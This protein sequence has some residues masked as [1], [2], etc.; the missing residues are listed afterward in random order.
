MSTDVWTK[1]LVNQRMTR[2]LPPEGSSVEYTWRCRVTNAQGAELQWDPFSFVDNTTT[3]L[4]LP[5]PG[6]KVSD[7]FTSIGG[8]SDYFRFRTLQWSLVPESISTWEVTATATSKDAFC[9]EPNV[10]RTD[11]VTSREVDVYRAIEPADTDRA[12]GN[13]LA[14]SFYADRAGKPIKLNLGQIQISISFIWNTGDDRQDGNGNPIGGYPN[15]A[16]VAP[17]INTRNDDAFLGFAAGTLRLVGVNIDPEQH[18]Y[19]RVTYQFLWDQ[20]YHLTQQP[21]V[22]SQGQPLTT[23]VSGQRRAIE[24]TWEQLYDEDDWDALNFFS[25]YELSWLTEGW[26]SWDSIDCGTTLSLTGESAVGPHSPSLPPADSEEEEGPEP[27]PEP[28]PEET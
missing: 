10:L 19:V 15:P 24:V 25:A 6:D 9:P 11:S 4:S 12:G 3:D 28:P 7:V 18:E 14:N 20:W 5:R 22:S 27:E 1:T 21:K 2:G 13:T 8:W 17:Y 23:D 16:G 26:L